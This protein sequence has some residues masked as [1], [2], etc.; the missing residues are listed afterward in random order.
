LKD[1]R[2]HLDAANKKEN[3]H[4]HGT[5]RLVSKEARRIEGRTTII[6]QM[7]RK[8]GETMGIIITD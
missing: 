6:R 1:R 2:Q 3:D 8:G 7:K 4:G 5:W